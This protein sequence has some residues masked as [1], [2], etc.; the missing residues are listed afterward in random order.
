[1]A[2]SEPTDP[3]AVDL[4]LDDRRKERKRLKAR[5]TAIVKQIDAHI[6]GRL[7]RSELV[8]LVAEMNGLTDLCVRCNEG[9]R[10][11]TITDDNV[12]AATKWTE[13][14]LLVAAACRERADHYLL[15]RADDVSS[16]VSS[17]SSVAAAYQVRRSAL[18]T[19]L[20]RVKLQHEQAERQRQLQLAHERE[21]FKE[22]QEQLMLKREIEAL[23][24]EELS[25]CADEDL[26]TRP[27]GPFSYSDKVEPWLSASGAPKNDNGFPSSD[28][29]GTTQRAQNRFPS[30]QRRPS[31]T[32]IVHDGASAVQAVDVIQPRTGGP[33]PIPFVLDKDNM[34][35]SSTPAVPPTQSLHLCHS[36][37]ASRLPKMEIPKF[38]GR[39]RDW[40]MFI[41][42]FRQSV[43]DVL[44]SDADR[45][46][47]LRELLSDG[48]KGSVSKYLYHP[49][50]YQELLCVLER[51]YGNPQKIVHACLKSIEALPTWKDF[52]LPGLRRFSNELQGIVATLSLGDHCAELE[53][54]G[55]LMAVVKRMPERLRDDWGRHVVEHYSRQRPSL[56]DLS[57]WLETRTEAAEM[58]SDESDDEARAKPVHAGRRFRRPSV[59]TAVVR[60]TEQPPVRDGPAV[61]APSGH[62]CVVCRGNHRLARCKTFQEMPIE[63]RADVI[64]ANNCCYRCL[65]NDHVSRNCSSRQRCRKNGCNALHHPLFH[66][67]PRLYPARPCS[68]SRTTEQPPEPFAGAVKQ[69][70]RAAKWACMLPIVPLLV[71]GRDG[72]MIRTMALLDKGSEVS[73]IRLDL[74][75][76]LHLTGPTE[77]CRF[78]TFHANDPTLSVRRVSFTVRSQ[79]GLFELNIEDAYA[80]PKLHLNRKAV[81]I[82]DIVS[83][84]EYLRE[85]ERELPLTG[86]EVAVL[87]G[88]DNP[89]AHEIIQYRTDPDRP[90]SP[91]ATL[92]PFGWCLVG[93]FAPYSGLH[94]RKCFGI[95]LADTSDGSSLSEMMERFFDVDIFGMKPKD[96]DITSPDERRALRIL[97]ATTR[98]TGERYEAGLLWKTDDPRLPDN[99]LAALKRFYALERRL[100]SDPCLA[101]KYVAVIEEYLRHDHAK[102]LTTEEANTRPSAKQIT[103]RLRRRRQIE[104]HLAQYRVT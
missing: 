41:T 66:G 28:V 29:L 37:L 4:S 56:C 40:P 44:D 45:L 31:A 6:R 42:S 76:K 21:R 104:G 101:A 8:S 95:T 63:K 7:S 62:P 35:L 15:Q 19:E 69:R 100:M 24:E 91:Q 78:A 82:K 86:G 98:F 92:T 57:D 9:I 25:L 47:I 87:I 89:S 49:K 33:L 22:E 72:R 65:E 43:H 36:L 81:D 75:D 85:I 58:V 11:L 13:D 34:N 52:D 99:R 50:C 54:A 80:V 30:D 102:I 77:S 64:K 79:D 74:A 14:V 26:H 97:E 68:A 60:H 1:M 93:P 32:S 53:S 94:S 103:R 2:A 5:H 27:A 16:V 90:R 83:R 48:V 12:A 61:G 71:A 70:P 88:I 96:L 51:R 67:A 3:A 84:F 10:S 23:D 20:E 55:N 59:Y 38:S 39:A 18:K 46:N 17:R 73:M